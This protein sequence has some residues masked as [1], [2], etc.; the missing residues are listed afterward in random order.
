MASL[1]IIVAATCTNGI[2]QGARLP[3]RLPAEMAYFAR[4]T[5]A[6]PPECANAVIM[7]RKTWESIPKSRRPLVDRYNVIITSDPKY[8]L[9]V[10]VTYI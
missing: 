8:D 4:V 7:G 10:S 6:A 3:W 9:C 2:G 1:T 5:K